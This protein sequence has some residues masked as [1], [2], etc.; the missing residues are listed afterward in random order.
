MKKGI[1]IF[2]VMS[3]ILLQQCWG[4]SAQDNDYIREE[5]ANDVMDTY[6]YITQEFSLPI[7]ERPIFDDI[8]GSQYQIRITQAYTKGFMD[9]IDEKTFAP[10]QKVTNMQAITVIYRLIEE[11]NQKYD[12]VWPKSTSVDNKELSEMPVWSKEAIKYLLEREI[13]SLEEGTYYNEDA[14]RDDV[15]LILNKI[16]GKYNTSYSG[17]RIDFDEFLK[18]IQE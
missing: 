17:Q 14:D 2:L 7:V 18:R 11:L 1:I 10:C 3:C 5:L 8:G 15:N 9:G 12:T 6:E 16:K 4:V 13:I